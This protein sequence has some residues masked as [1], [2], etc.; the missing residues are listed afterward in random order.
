M[1]ELKVDQIGDLFFKAALRI[2]W[3]RVSLAPWWDNA[4]SARRGFDTLRRSESTSTR[5]NRRWS[6][7]SLTP[8]M[9]P[10]G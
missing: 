8:M 10:V 2:S 6:I 3:A 4:L 9:W 7:R 1:V 5:R